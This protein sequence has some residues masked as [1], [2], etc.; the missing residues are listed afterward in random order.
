MIPKNLLGCWF[1]RGKKSDLFLMCEETKQRQLPEWNV[2]EVTEDTIDPELLACPYMR[3][4]LERGEF[5]KAT[6]LGRLWALHKYGGVYL[7][8]DVEV[9]KPLDPLLDS[10]FFIG[11]EDS[12][13]INGAVIGSMQAGATITALLEAFP[14]NSDGGAIATTYGPMFLTQ[15]MRKLGGYLYSPEFFYP[16]HYDG[17][18]TITGNSFTRHWWAG[19][20]KGYA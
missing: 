12:H 6:E 5:V 13:M 17:T 7:D 20:W 8:E 4:V 14:V 10:P 15:Q 18:G 11:W 1:G 9:L 16:V 19:S 2:I 3:G